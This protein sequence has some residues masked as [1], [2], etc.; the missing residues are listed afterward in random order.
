MHIAIVTAGGAGMFCGSCMHDNSWARA[1]HAAG[2]EVSLVPTY[3]PIRVDEPNASGSRVFFGGLNVYLNATSRIWRAIPRPLK[4]WLDRPGILNLLSRMSGSN[5]AAQLGDLTLGMLDGDAGPHAAAVQELA[6]FLGE[7]LRPD[8]VIFSNALLGGAV[9][10][11]RQSF[12]GPVLVV[13]Q[14]DDVFLDGLPPSHKQAA[15]TATGMRA[16]QF[17]ACLTHTHFYRDYMAKYLSLPLEAFETLPLSIDASE[18]GGRPR[19]ETGQPPTIG[20]FARIAPEKGL[21]NLVDAVDILRLRRPDVRLLVGGYLGRQ[22]SEYFDSIRETVRNW[23][24]GFQ[25]VGSPDT[26][27][28]KVDFFRR[29]DVVSVPTEFLEPKGLYVLESL[30]NGVPVVQPAHGSFPELI[31]STEG[32]WLVEPRNPGALAE[33]LQRVLEQPDQRREAGRRGYAAV[34]ERHSP[35]AL[36]RQTVLIL[37]RML[38]SRT[39]A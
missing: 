17:D 28:G 2:H 16:R 36:A 5:D 14:G 10:A 30:A 24:D 11:L 37:E 3:T 12:S 18:H 29:C 15:I 13:L 25:H 35:A 31:E 1:L 6:A 21:R 34:R 27:A 26:L 33:Q 9:G 7:Q 22:H 19:D 32:G 8:I 4:R 20:Y 23:G 39:A 38:S